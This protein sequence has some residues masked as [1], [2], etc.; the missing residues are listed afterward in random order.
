MYST[1][2]IFILMRQGKTEY[3]VKWVGWPESA[4]TW[5]TEDDLRNAQKLVDRFENSWKQLEERTVCYFDL[6]IYLFSSLCM[7]K[8]ARDG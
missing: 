1:S 3:Y 2:E 5:Q 8:D 7:M 6:F 4:N